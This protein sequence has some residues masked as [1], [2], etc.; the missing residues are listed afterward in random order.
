M[1]ASHH[2]TTFPPPPTSRT[3]PAYDLETGHIFV[4][5][6]TLSSSL[7]FFFSFDLT[8]LPSPSSPTPTLIHRSSQFPWRRLRFCVIGITSSS[9]SQ[10]R[11]HSTT[12]IHRRPFAN[13]PSDSTI[14]LVDDLLH[15]PTPPNPLL[16]LPKA[17]NRSSSIRA[18][19]ADEE[20][21]LRLPIPSSQHQK[22]MISNTPLEVVL[23]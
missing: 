21:A 20:Q 15:L 7:L 16:E 13:C 9:C 6:R 23:R 8:F 4:V 2:P 1:L 12:Q 10:Q 18:D 3:Q 17:D 22:H 11:Q 19:K 14:L 5:R